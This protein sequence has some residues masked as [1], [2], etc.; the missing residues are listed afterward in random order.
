MLA[1]LASNLGLRWR[2]SG[3]GSARTGSCRALKETKSTSQTSPTSASITVKLLCSR[4]WPWFVSDR[5]QETRIAADL[6]ASPG[7]SHREALP[8]RSC[9][10][11]PSNELR[12]SIRVC[13]YRWSCCHVLGTPFE[14]ARAERKRVCWWVRR[15]LNGHKYHAISEDTTTP[16]VLLTGRQVSGGCEGSRQGRCLSL[17]LR[18]SRVADRARF[19]GDIQVLSNDTSVRL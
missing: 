16:A 17:T 1:T 14:N 10:S 9:G 12:R 2:S 4:R 15:E 19:Q 3:T 7:F 5:A 18:T 13:G 6:S 11:R 8:T